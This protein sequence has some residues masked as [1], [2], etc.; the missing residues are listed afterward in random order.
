MLS[1][2][3]GKGFTYRHFLVGVLMKGTMVFT[4]VARGGTLGFGAHIH[5]LCT[6][7]SSFLSL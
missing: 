2:E 7:D 3:C 4:P 1:V 6:E 5:Q